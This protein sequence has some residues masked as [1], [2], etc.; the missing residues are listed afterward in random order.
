MF[1]RS[2]GKTALG[3]VGAGRPGQRPSRLAAAPVRWDSSLLALGI[4]PILE[5]ESVRTGSDQD[6]ALPIRVGA[7]ST[8][9][10][11]IAHFIRRC[12]A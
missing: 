3:I 1:R 10:R 12:G 8:P 2:T 4:S 9:E 11:N 6:I 5:G 7:D